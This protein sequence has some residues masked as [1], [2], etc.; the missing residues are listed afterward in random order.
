MSRPT[1]GL[2]IALP[3]MQ[4]IS[5]WGGR[6]GLRRGEASYPLASVSRLRANAMD[7]EVGERGG[8]A[9]SI[10]GGSEIAR[11][12]RESGRRLRFV[13]P[14]VGRA[15]LQQGHSGLWLAVEEH[16]AGKQLL[17]WR[18]WP[19]VDLSGAIALVALSAL[20]AGAAYAHSWAAA[21][22]GGCAILIGARNT[23]R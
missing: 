9:G 2:I 21:V 4:P 16:G 15:R 3:A 14:A 11:L 18:V 20:S 5:D 7:R 12:A 1:G 10:T 13:G 6:P 17:R 19:R 22:L 8:L 23:G